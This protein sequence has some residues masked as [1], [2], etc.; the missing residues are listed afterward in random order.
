MHALQVPV[1][2]VALGRQGALSLQ[3]GVERAQALQLH[4]H[5]LHEQL[6]DALAQLYDHALHH[7]AGV[8]G[9]VRHDVVGETPGV[10]SG[11]SHGVRIPFA[12]GAAAPVVVLTQVVLHRNLALCLVVHVFTCLYGL[13]L[14]RK[15]SDKRRQRQD[16]SRHAGVCGSFHPTFA[17]LCLVTLET[18]AVRPQ[19]F[20][21]LK[22]C[23]PH[24]EALQLWERGRLARSRMAGRRPFL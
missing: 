17:R 19:I 15:G 9:A 22:P 6:H 20:P 2:G 14:C 12:E 24:F 11:A 21:T 1:Y 18:R 16:F 7:V 8:D 3:G 4:A 10:E 13:K 23:N 5:T